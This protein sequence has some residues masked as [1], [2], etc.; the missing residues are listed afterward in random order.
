MI[1]RKSEIRLLANLVCH[2]LQRHIGLAGTRKLAEAG[3][4]YS[5]NVEKPELR[6]NTRDPDLT[7]NT[8]GL[9]RTMLKVRG[10]G[11]PPKFAGKTMLR[12]G[13]LGVHIIVEN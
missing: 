8:D 1:R 5:I 10:M 12:A 4:D 11:P 7:R 9:S 6:K 13:N 2:L 3:S